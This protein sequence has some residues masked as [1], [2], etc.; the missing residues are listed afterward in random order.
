MKRRGHDVLITMSDKDLARNLLERY[1]IPYVSFGSYGKKII[2]K[3]FT[4]PLLDIRMVKVVWNFKPDVLIGVGSIRCAHAGKLCQKK[5]L[6]VDDTE[7][8]YFGQALYRPFA[9]S[10]ITPSCFK[11]NFGEKQIRV[12][13]TTDLFYLHPSSIS[14][15]SNVLN[16]IG[17]TESET[18]SVIRFVAFDANHDIG[19]SGIKNRI[20]FVNEML[21]YGKVFISS[22]DEIPHELKKY[23]ITLPPEKMHDLMYYATLFVGESGT[24]ATEAACLGTHAIVINSESINTDGIYTAGVHDLYANYGLLECYKTDDESFYARIKELHSN[25]SLK[26]NSRKQSDKFI[27]DHDDMTKFLVNYVEGLI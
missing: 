10:I 7:H 19:Q 14:P 5:S 21:K 11:R 27:E 6:I 4:L 12:N 8:A 25:I 18:F 13:G 24:M 9:T 17:L 2:T 3:L 16:M 26:I 1:N 23:L 20:K 22:E 15:D